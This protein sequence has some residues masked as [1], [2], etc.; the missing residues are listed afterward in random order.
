MDD[1]QLNKVYYWGASSGLIITKKTRC[2]IEYI[3]I[4]ITKNYENNTYTYKNE[5]P[6]RSKLRIEDNGNKIYVK[7]GELSSKKIYFKSDSYS[8]YDLLS[9]KW[10]HEIEQR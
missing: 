4:Y 7:C 1:L 10:K 9:D 8:T 2:F 5:I 3:T 6:Y